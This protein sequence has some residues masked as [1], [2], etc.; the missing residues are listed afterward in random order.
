MDLMLGAHCSAN[1]SI[2]TQ[3]SLLL[4]SSSE[5]F[6]HASQKCPPWKYDLSGVLRG[7]V[8]QDMVIGSSWKGVG[9]SLAD[10]GSIG[11]AG[12]VVARGAGIF[13]GE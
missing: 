9:L 13:M 6:K 3:E 8:P 2:E 10:G 5:Q 7:T 12:G 1:Q 4:P 11:D